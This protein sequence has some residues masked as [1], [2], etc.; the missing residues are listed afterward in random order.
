MHFESKHQRYSRWKNGKKRQSNDIIMIKLKSK[1]SLGI[2]TLFDCGGQRRK[3]WALRGFEQ[4]ALSRMDRNPGRV[5]WATFL[6]ASR[7]TT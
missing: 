7:L 5:F 3:P 4:E 2:H 1:S 6:S